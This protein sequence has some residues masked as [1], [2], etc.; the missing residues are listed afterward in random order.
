VLD[1]DHVVAEAEEEG[2]AQAIREDS[3]YGHLYVRERTCGD[4]EGGEKR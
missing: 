3:G 1:G 4:E 2:Q